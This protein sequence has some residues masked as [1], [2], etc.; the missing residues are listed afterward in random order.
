MRTPCSQ[1]SCKESLPDMELISYSFILPASFLLD[2]IIGDPLALPHPVRWLGKWI[3]KW[4]PYF[5]KLPFSLFA[6]G[7]LFALSLI[8]G[9]YV[10]AWVVVFIS[11]IVHPYVCIAMQIL[12]LYYSISVKSLRSAAMGIYRSLKHDD[13]GDARIKVSQIVGRDVERLDEK[14][15][16][17]AAVESVAENLVDGVISPIFFAL[18]GGAPLAFAYKM[19]NTLDSMIGYRDEKYGEFGKCAAHIDDVANFV[20]ARISIIFIAFAAIISKGGMKRA[21]MTALK[22]GRNN[23][24]PNSG[25]SEAAFAGALG[26]RLGG[27]S[28]YKGTLLRKP[29]IGASF[30]ETDIEHIR[31]A[32]NL[33]IVSASLWLIACWW[34]TI[35]FLSLM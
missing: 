8:A 35:G 18:M 27:P 11:N 6:S 13:L 32:C 14:G 20:P 5:R 30:G 19:V 10:I 34:I 21:F 7:C 17:R 26:I 2:L 15:I 29:Y 33:M 16:S 1:K 25:F 9:T 28:F 24:S 31:K 3:E 4:E 22:E 12:L 23:P